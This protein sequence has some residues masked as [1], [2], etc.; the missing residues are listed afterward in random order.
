M[1]VE[2]QVPGWDL[3][4]CPCCRP[5]HHLPYSHP[6]PH[7]RRRLNRLSTCHYLHRLLLH[8]SFVSAIYPR[9]DHAAAL[10]PPN[11]A[12]LDQL[13]PLSCSSSAQYSQPLL[14][15]RQ[16]AGV[17]EHTLMLSKRVE[18]YNRRC[19]LRAP[20]YKHQL[21]NRNHEPAV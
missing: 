12:G 19:E 14:V 7:P 3:G 18:E 8:P 6:Y 17:F 1:E 2:K 15:V 10:N 9:V 16:N 5:L 21:K 11:R 4:H 20:K 13:A